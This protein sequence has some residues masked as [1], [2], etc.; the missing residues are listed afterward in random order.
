MY[1]GATENVM[2]LDALASVPITSGAA[3]A[4]GVKYEVADGVQNL[5]VGE[6]KFAGHMGDGG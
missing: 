6:R 5:N 1:S 4:R 3:F 2:S